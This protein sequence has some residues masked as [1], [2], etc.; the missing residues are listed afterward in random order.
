MTERRK[1]RNGNDTKCIVYI[2]V[3]DVY[4]DEFWGGDGDICARSKGNFIIRIVPST[5][6]SMKEKVSTELKA[7][8]ALVL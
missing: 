6:V 8:S 4:S 2:Y 3:V 5:L 7:T 1:D